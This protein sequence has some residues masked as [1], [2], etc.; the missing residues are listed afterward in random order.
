MPEAQALETLLRG[1]AGYVAAPRVE[2]VV[3]AS[4]Y[5]RIVLMPGVA[6]AL[7][8]AGASSQPAMNMGGGRGRQS[9]LPAFD[10]TVDENSETSQ[11]AP[12][13]RERHAMEP[14]PT[15]TVSRVRAQV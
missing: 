11:T 14:V 3:A 4:S 6:P 1:T 10:T 7:P 2:R 13:D 15:R 5:D 9:N 8:A 12:W